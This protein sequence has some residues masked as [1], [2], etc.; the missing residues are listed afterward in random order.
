MRYDDHSYTAV[1]ENLATRNNGLREIDLIE[2]VIQPLQDARGSLADGA[3][4]V[5]WVFSVLAISPVDGG[6]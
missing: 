3:C 1:R 6:S 5:E 4:Q 2:V